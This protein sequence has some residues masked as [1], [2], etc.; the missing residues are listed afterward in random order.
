[1]AIQV[2]VPKTLAISRWNGISYT[3][4]LSARDEMFLQAVKKL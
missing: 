1:M 2:L 3:S 4:D